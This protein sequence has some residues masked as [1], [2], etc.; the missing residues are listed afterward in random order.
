MFSRK[1]FFIL[2][3]I[4]FGV[5]V[6]SSDTFAQRMRLPKTQRKQILQQQLP[7]DTRTFKGVVYETRGARSLRLDL[8][9]PSMSAGKPAPVVV[10]F[11]RD[12]NMAVPL[13][14]VGNGF[15]VASVEV[16]YGEGADAFPAGTEDGKSAVRFLKANAAQYGLDQDRMALCGFSKWGMIATLVGVSADVKKWEVGSNLEHNSRVQAVVNISGH[17]DLTTVDTQQAKSSGTRKAFRSKKG[18]SSKNQEYL[19]CQPN[20]C[21]E[22]EKEASALT[23]VSSDD[24][25]FFLLIGQADPLVPLSQMTNFRKKLQEV[26]VNSAL[27]IVPGVGHNAGDLIKAEQTN[28]IVFL[29]QYLKAE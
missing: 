7:S 3:V 23:H 18:L 12:L 8:Y 28:I 29:K 1:R 6:L 10:W 25:A 4:S 13:F 2:L 5:I 22:L 9:V 11:A 21:A 16:R 20:M 26:G 15:A 24:P 27:A 14:F 19:N 17:T